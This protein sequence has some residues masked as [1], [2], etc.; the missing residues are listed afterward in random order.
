MRVIIVN[1]FPEDWSILRRHH[2]G[3][4]RWSLSGGSTNLRISKE[5]DDVS[6]FLKSNSEQRKTPKMVLDTHSEAD[7]PCSASTPTCDCQS[8]SLDDRL[9]RAAIDIVLQAFQT[10][11][12]R[13]IN[14]TSDPTSIRRV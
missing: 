14:S 1:Q 11:S 13:I 7:T 9:S 12:W 10:T 5:A 2:S 4:L 3:D 8:P 6:L